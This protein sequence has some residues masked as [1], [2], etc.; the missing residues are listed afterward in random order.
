M[1]QN[2]KK[3]YFWNTLGSAAT[4][5]TSF[6]LTVIIARINNIEDLGLYTF[7]FG[8]AVIFAMIS[9]FGG[10]NFQITDAKNE[11]TA[12]EYIA[13][14]V[15]ASAI[16][17]FVTVV[18]ILLNQYD[19]YVSMFIIILLLYKILDSCTDV[20]AATLQKKHHLWIA[21]KWGFSKRFLV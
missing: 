1:R 18:I 14:R 6:V 16:A 2:L 19:L 12:E 13:Q 15:V 21:G 3:D 7:A 5:C 11:F 20:V 4:A 17:I 10:R 8:M 9:F